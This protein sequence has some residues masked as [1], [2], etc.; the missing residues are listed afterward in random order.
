MENTKIKIENP[1]GILAFIC[2]VFLGM[3]FILLFPSLFTNT[4]TQCS[5]LR[6]SIYAFYL[7]AFIPPALVIL[8]YHLFRGFQQE[9]IINWN[10]KSIAIKK[11]IL[12]RGAS[13]VTYSASEIDSLTLHT[14]ESSSSNIGIKFVNGDTTSV[15]LSI[16]KDNN[17]DIMERASI[18]AKAFDYSSPIKHVHD[19]DSGGGGG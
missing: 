15:P 1:W 10:D 3:G 16:I 7:V 4:C 8:L 9:V 2:L 14:G 19:T 18:F 17:L 6:S 11:H 12:L 5:R 13:S